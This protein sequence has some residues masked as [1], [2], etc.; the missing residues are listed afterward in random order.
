LSSI[1]NDKVE[2]TSTAFHLERQLLL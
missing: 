1:D 2:W